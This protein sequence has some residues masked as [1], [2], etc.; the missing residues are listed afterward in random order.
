MKNQKTEIIK[1]EESQVKFI[2]PNYS[3]ET[4]L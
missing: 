1:K 2:K 3:E 4:M